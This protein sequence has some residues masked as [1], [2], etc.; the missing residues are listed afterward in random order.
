MSFIRSLFILLAV[1]SRSIFATDDVN[2]LEGNFQSIPCPKTP[3]SGNQS[4]C[5]PFQ[6]MSRQEQDQFQSFALDRV[7]RETYGTI[8]TIFNPNVF[9]N[10]NVLGTEN[11]SAYPLSF[12]LIRRSR[13]P[14]SSTDEGLNQLWV[15]GWMKKYNRA[16]VAAA[17]WWINEALG[18]RTGV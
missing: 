4:V 17:I 5:Q 12:V 9:D 7:A 10:T 3:I 11:E 14:Y 6:G 18:Q 1:F 13:L 15:R 16:I 8:L 2:Q